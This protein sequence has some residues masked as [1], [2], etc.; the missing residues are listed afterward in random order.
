[1]WKE[2][3]NNMGYFA[4]TFGRKGTAYFVAGKKCGT[5]RKDM[6]FLLFFLTMAVYYGRRMFLLTP[7]YDELYTYY[8]FISRGPVYAAIHWPLPN[9]HVGYSTLS[10][11]LGIFG[12]APVALRGVSYLCSLGS[13]VLLYRISKK[14][15]TEGVALVP[16]FVFAGMYMVNQLAV[17]GRGYA[18]VTFCYLSA[19]S[20]LYAIVEEKQE[21]R[22]NYM[23]FGTALVIALWA[24][25]S[26]LYVVMPVCMIGGFVLLL[27]RDYRRLLRLIIVSLTSAVCTAGLYGILWLAIGSNLLSKTPDGPFYMAGHIDIILHAPFRALR[28]GI[29][30]ML[31]TPYIQSMAR[32]EFWS[33]AGHWLETLFGLQLSPWSGF[34]G[35]GMCVLLLT[36]LLSAVVCLVRR[37][38]KAFWEWYFVLTAV[39]LTLAL[40]IQCKLPYQRVFSFLGVW[41]A[42]LVGWLAQRLLICLEKLPDIRYKNGIKK[43]YEAFVYIAT[44]VSWAFVLAD[45]T[46]YSIRDELIADA[47]EQID[48]EDSD[49]LAVTDCDQEYLLLYLYGIQDE[50]ITRS[51][52]E[53]DTVL[54][55]K[56]L[57]GMPYGY[58]E[59]PEEWKFYLT[60]ED[61][62]A[63]QAYIEANMTQIYENWQFILFVGNQARTE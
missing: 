25:P 29:K 23:I 37:P 34:F 7:W 21:C 42:F 12:C 43:G 15:L 4:K 61:V 33:Q 53:A 19:L 58:R 32:Q 56:A 62:E 18:L 41:A 6:V 26:S 30:Y 11:C 47:Y 49:I 63:K 48:I 2:S 17:Q 60:Q 40:L 46:A 57:L 20:S 44:G 27:D 8:Y 51:L 10:A 1:M 38:K 28:E 13:L 24:V 59:S 39:L 9:N 36:G 5:D 22:R 14:Y 52:E 3:N 45:M 31:D 35:N 54:L 50:Q 16:V 55:D